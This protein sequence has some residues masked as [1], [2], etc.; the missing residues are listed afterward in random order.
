MDP[1]GFTASLLT[2][3]STF[4]FLTTFI[5]TLL[6]LPSYVR[7]LLDQLSMC[8]D[9]LN[10]LNDDITT[11]LSL[12]LPEDDDRLQAAQRTTKRAKR[13]LR[14]LGTKMDLLGSGHSNYFVG[15]RYY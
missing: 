10:L 1:V 14:K 6:G 11:H 8:H 3:I 7:D 4:R 13:I 9:V 15:N 12:N 5:S 2:L